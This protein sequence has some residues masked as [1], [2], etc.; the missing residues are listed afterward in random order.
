LCV[1]GL[2]VPSL[3]MKKM[4]SMIVRLHVYVSDFVAFQDN[5]FQNT[6]NGGEYLTRNVIKGLSYLLYLSGWNLRFEFI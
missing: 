2:D 6:Q 1:K 5:L 3:Q 4:L